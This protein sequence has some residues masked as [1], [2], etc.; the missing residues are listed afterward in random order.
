MQSDSKIQIH[1]HII[2]HNIK[3]ESE[4]VILIIG[5]YK[6]SQQAHITNIKNNNLR[7]STHR[8]GSCEEHGFDQRNIYK[9]RTFEAELNGPTGSGPTGPN[10][11]IMYKPKPLRT[12]T[13][14]N[15][16]QARNNPKIKLGLKTDTVVIASLLIML[17]CCYFITAYFHCYRKTKSLYRL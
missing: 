12:N 3:A 16:N 7:S 4:R 9:L 17:V 2:C 13:I 11:K 1:S 10:S 8:Q 6:Y 14:S 15:P 5:W